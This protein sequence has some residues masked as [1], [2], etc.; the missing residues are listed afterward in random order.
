MKMR[1]IRLKLDNFAGI[2]SGQVK[3]G[4][5]LNILYGPN[6]LGKSTLAESIR[7]VL[8]MQSN[9]KAHEPWVRWNTDE[10][11]E[12]E[13]V[14]Q[15]DEQRYW[16]VKK[17]FGFGAK[18]SATF[19]ESKDGVN[20]ANVAKARR[21][22][23]EIRKLL[24]WGIPE[25]GGG[26]SVK[27]LPETFLTAVLLPQQ[28]QVDDIF[29]RHL[30]EDYDDSGKKLLTETLQALAT[31]P[32]FASVL[33]EAQER[34]DEAFT[35]NGRRRS[36]KHS[37][38][39]KLSE[40]IKLAEDRLRQ[41][42]EDRDRSE[43]VRREIRTLHEQ[44]EQEVEKHDAACEDLQKH[45]KTHK[46]T[47]E[48]T[49][50]LDAAEKTLAAVQKI[51]SDYEAL[52]KR[53]QDLKGHVA[54][55]DGQRQE[56]AKAVA[57]A[58][59]RVKVAED[60]VQAASSEQS[61]AELRIKRQGLEN[62]LLTLDGNITKAEGRRRQ[63]VELRDANA[64]L[65]KL[66][67]GMQEAAEQVERLKSQIAEAS[68]EIEILTGLELWEQ[69]R[70]AQTR[71]QGAVEAANA[72]EKLKSQNAKATGEL[73]E[74]ES[75]LSKL[76]LPTAEQLQAIKSLY[77]D[78]RVAEGKL[79][80][81]L[82]VQ[83]TPLTKLEIQAS[84]DGAA[85]TR[86]DIESAVTLDAD[87]RLDLT[88]SNI[89][90]I[91]VEGG[92]PETRAAAVSQLEQ[93]V[94]EL[95]ASLVPFDE[96]VMVTEAKAYESLAPERRATAI[97]AA[98]G[99]KNQERQQRQLTLAEQQAGLT[100]KRNDQEK[101]TADIAAKAP[102]LDAPWD[103]ILPAADASLSSYQQQRESLTKQL[104]ALEKEG[105]TELAAAQ[106]ELKEAK[107][108]REGAEDSQWK[109]TQQ[110][111]EATA[112][113]NRCEGEVTLGRAARD[114]ADLVQAEED[115]ERL[116]EARAELTQGKAPITLDELET[117]RHQVQE[118]AAAVEETRRKLGNQEGALRHVGGD[119]VSERYKAYNDALQ[120]KQ[121]EEAE[122][123]LEYD[124]WQMLLN[125]L[126]EVENDE[127]AHLGSA[128]VDP[129]A[130]RFG[131]LTDS[132]YGQ[133]RLGPNLETLGI[134]AQGDTREVGR[135]SVGTREQLSTILR[136]TLAEQL[137]SV[138][139]LDDQLTQSDPQRI[140]WF[141]EQFRLLARETQIV[142]MTCRPLDYLSPNEMPQDREYAESSD[143]LVRAVHLSMLVKSE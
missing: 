36:G 58:N 112:N 5:G 51:H 79:E 98:I 84:L 74:V 22:D 124:A 76:Q 73:E 86:H 56:K 117:K 49:A 113:L 96:E 139:V 119:I 95:V 129:V 106:R 52:L 32:Q 19:D 92:N 59:T 15:T 91:K 57:E 48:L 35:T 1:F 65:A 135:L 9:S 31:D 21:V 100:N 71:L 140:D 28:D 111:T 39:K 50:Q 80:V 77:G 133:M 18:S 83:I 53:Q 62:D 23:S 72:I 94:A 17:S 46:A 4:P 42:R 141:R 125:T 55:L 85:A 67:T 7:A 87:A 27:G 90:E 88:L 60:A 120:Q 103:E 10:P 109:V 54:D 29:A 13:L 20:F 99:G 121:S 47:A 89:A 34:V 43:E 44:L 108:A 63:A 102:Q 14:F 128:I 24:N 137:G 41:S 93:E 38:W 16:R 3:F 142:V 61:A 97:R 110:H 136:F 37:L 130:K 118:L 68:Q 64:E 33:K 25:P 104:A 11:P 6:E 2:A 81:G 101:I 69:K 40:E 116:R 107:K 8:L 66:T 75:R 78:L 123:T 45:E 30:G 115:V 122:V 82:S 131:E 26:G 105:E 134:V 126:R 127:A 138:L 132:R 12:V 70:V 143:S 114:A